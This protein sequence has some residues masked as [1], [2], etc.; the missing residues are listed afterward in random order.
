MWLVI[1]YGNLLRSDDCFGAEVC[2]TLKSYPSIE[3]LAKII[4]VHQLTP[5]L[6]DLI[7]QAKG[8]IFVDASYDLAPGQLRFIPLEK[9]LT[10][11]L[12]SHNCTPQA[13][14]SETCRLYGSTPSGW[15]CAAGGI[16]FEL[17]EELSPHLQKIVPQAVKLIMEKVAAQ[18]ICI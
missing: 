3:S 1:G 18:E 2:R 8:V 11:Q 14:L 12:L 5:E 10:D 13:L 6:V 9:A 16:N 7:N 17:G 15:L 4:I